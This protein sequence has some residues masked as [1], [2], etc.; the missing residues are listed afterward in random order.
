MTKAAV[1]ILAKATLE[2]NRFSKLEGSFK[3]PS[4]VSF[5]IVQVSMQP[6]TCPNTCYFADPMKSGGLHL[7]AVSERA[8]G[9]DGI[10]NRFCTALA[11][12]IVT[13]MEQFNEEVLAGSDY[14]KVSK[15]DTHAMIAKKIRDTQRRFQSSL[16]G[17]IKLIEI[18]A[19]LSPE[20]LP[21]LRDG[22]DKV[23]VYEARIF[24]SSPFCFRFKLTRKWS[25]KV[26]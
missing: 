5:P 2:F 8:K 21:A 3:K 16:L 17:Y 24:F 15:N 6:W 23:I 14:G 11:H 22:N 20:M 19:A 1:S 12:I 9:L 18:L 26:F 4:T 7:E 10:A 25:P 13:V